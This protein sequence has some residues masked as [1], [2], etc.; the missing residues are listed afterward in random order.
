MSAHDTTS[1]LLLSAMLVI[2]VQSDL[3]Q[4]RIPNVLSLPGIIAAL[5]LHGLSD[6]LHGLAS[7]LGGAAVGFVCFVP[8]YLLRG[9]GAGDVKLL[10]AVGAFLGP[11]GALLA[12]LY[13][14]LAGGFAAIGHVLWQA[15]RASAIAWVREGATAMSVSAFVAAQNAR[16][17]RLAFA[18]P[19]AMGSIAAVFQQV[20]FTNMVS[21]PLRWFS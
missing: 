5:A 12:A 19:I 17:D 3:R 9:M 16:R 1:L 6:G 4:R 2:A 20:G 7:G 18:L 15:V 21:W 8:F 11:Q 13:S 14:L 10:A